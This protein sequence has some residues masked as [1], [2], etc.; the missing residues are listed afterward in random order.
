MSVREQQQTIKRA[1]H[2]F[3]TPLSC[4]PGLQQNT[5]W[6]AELLPWH[7]SS[8]PIAI[9]Q[10]QR[11][12]PT[13]LL[14]K[15]SVAQRSLRHP[16]SPRA[17]LPP[18]LSPWHNNSCSTAGTL[19][20]LTCKLCLQSCTPCSTRF[21]SH[22]CVCVTHLLREPLCL[23]CCGQL[24]SQRLALLAALCQLPCQQT[25]LACL[26]PANKHNLER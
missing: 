22:R 2:L 19:P 21:W 26:Q 20:L 23:L 7:N 3:A 12:V 24:C 8:R 9:R 6:H 1:F 18:L 4:S 10:Y 16:P 15:T 25:Q 13:M 14:H 5:T 11:L 17:P